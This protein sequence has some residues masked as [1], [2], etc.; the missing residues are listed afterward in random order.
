MNVP[1]LKSKLEL[2]GAAASSS[3]HSLI[4]LPS[5]NNGSILYASNCIVNIAKPIHVS[6]AEKDTSTEGDNVLYNVNSTLRTCTVSRKD[7]LRSITTMTLLQSVQVNVGEQ[8]QR[9]LKESI[10]I[11]ACAFSDGTLT[12]WR[13]M[14]E[15]NWEEH[16]LVGVTNEGQE[17]NNTNQSDS[18]TDVE[19]ICRIKSSEDAPNMDQLEIIILTSSSMG[20]QYYKH[21]MEA[22]HNDQ[23]NSTSNNT[24]SAVLATYPTSCM[25]LTTIQNQLILAIGTAMPRHNR[26][27]FY[28]LPIVSLSSMEYGGE[29][30]WTH[31]GSLLGHLGWVNCLDWMSTDQYI[32]LASGSQDARIRLWKFHSPNPYDENQDDIDDNGDDGDDDD[33]DESEADDDDLI[34]EGEARMFIRFENN[35]GV[36]VQSA[37]ILEALLI[38][39]EENVTAVS[40]RPGSSKPCLISSSMDRSILIWMEESDNNEEDNESSLVTSGVGNVWAPMTRVGT[41]GGILGGS[42]GSSLLGFINIIWS[43]DGQQIIGHGYGGALYFWRKDCNVNNSETERWVANPCITGHFRGI[44]DISWEVTEGMYLLSAGLDQTCRLWTSLP[45]RLSNN[46]GGNVWREVG[47]PQVH[48]YDL[49]A[50]ACIGNG[51]GEMVHRFISGADEKE[52]RGFDAPIETL[53]LL[54][55]LKGKSSTDEN[56]ESRI[57]RA[58]IPSLGLSN[59]ATAADA[60]EEGG[61][62]DVAP[63]QTISNDVSLERSGD[64]LSA[65]EIAAAL[66]HERDLG[67]TSLWPEIRKLYG[68]QTE[69]ICLASNAE[70]CDGSNDKVLLA[71]SCKARDAENA[72]I[73]IWD[74]EN[75]M[76]LCSLKNGHKSTVTSLSFSSDGKY[77]ASTGKDRRLCFWKKSIIGEQLKYDLVSVVESAH[78]RIVWSLDFCPTNPGLICTGSRDGLLKLWQVT[79][80]NDDDPPIVKELHRWEPISKSDKK[81]EPITAVAFAPRTLHSCLIL[82]VGLETGILEIWAI[83][84]RLDGTDWRC[85]LLHSIPSDSCHIDAVKKLAWKPYRKTQADAEAFFDLT[86]ASCSA[87]HG[88][89]IF[90]ILEDEVL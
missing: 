25:K 29:S 14:D 78:K 63:D 31:Q 10:T 1:K 71:S 62:G 36:K 49:N 85:K 3:P 65:E 37:V 60:M 34:E 89:R 20:V 38:G 12:L 18:I 59:R 51:K 35:E 87:D 7:C 9:S 26:I 32:M 13:Q 17:L 48:G 82:A 55:F 33:D 79:D 19:G 67:V 54:K 6:G 66:P 88:V 84:T 11:I 45:S 83:P 50:V 76:C 86:L 40:W 74:V 15:H 90:R 39:H 70:R 27:H 4:T 16:V 24:Q 2:H 58:F 47:R 69:L 21:T 23:I 42:V 80:S 52:A 22:N 41:A 28:T 56:N 77:L 53:K 5:K 81:V 73:R 43:H 75:N 46:D 68:H 8:G 72:A 64:D 61:I 44:S 30:E 57:N